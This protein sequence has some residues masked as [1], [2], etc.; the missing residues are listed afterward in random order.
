[1][2]SGEVWKVMAAARMYWESRRWCIGRAGGGEPRAMAGEGHCEEEQ[3][4]NGA[5]DR[6]NKEDQRKNYRL[7]LRIPSLA[8]SLGL[9]F[10][11]S[12]KLVR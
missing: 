8:R 1:M 12:T 5:V 6:G 7:W 10:R 3:V 4:V 11:R 2:W 9:G